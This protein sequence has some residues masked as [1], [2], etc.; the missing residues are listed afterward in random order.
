LQKAF[1]CDAQK[2]ILPAEFKDL[3]GTFDG[4]L[5][6]ALNMLMSMS[7]LFTAVFTNAALHWCKRNPAGVVRSA[8]ELLKPGGRFVG[9][10]GGYLNCVG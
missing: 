2:L 6:I 3:S 1:C 5:F 8:K 9:E 10:F 4:M 7:K